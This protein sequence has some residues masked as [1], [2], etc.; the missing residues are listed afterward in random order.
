MLLLSLFLFASDHA[1]ADDMTSASYRLWFG[2]M[3]ITGGTKTSASYN[4]TDSVG[5][6][7][8]GQYG[9]GNNV[10]K[11]GFQYIYP[12]NTFTFKIS[13]LSIAFGSLPIGSFVSA[14]E[15]IEVTSIGAGGYSV[16]VS[17]D[18]P[19]QRGTG[20]TTIP[21]TSCDSGC[22]ETTATPWTNA[23]N[24]GFGYNVTG[25][26]ASTDFVNSTYYKRFANIAGGKVPQTIMSSTHVGTKRHGVLTY[27]IAIGA[28]QQAGDYQTQITYTI[29]PGY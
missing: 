17:E 26:D 7:A 6:T 4:V 20:A 19:L 11:S 8:P 21:D 2:T 28:S 13:P 9:L 1:R 18:H 24:T 10:V 22:T 27:K 23:A 29:I 25:D 5:Q 12:L 14:Q 3:N 15:T 16:K